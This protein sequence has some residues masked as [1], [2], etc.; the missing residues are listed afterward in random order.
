LK[1]VSSKPYEFRWGVK[2]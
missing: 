1:I 2:N